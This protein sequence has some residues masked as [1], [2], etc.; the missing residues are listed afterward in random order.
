MLLQYAVI[1]LL[2]MLAQIAVIFLE[3]IDFNN[4]SNEIISKVWDSDM[5]NDFKMTM[6]EIKVSIKPFF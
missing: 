2:L 1:M 6:Y 4:I 5:A 3:P